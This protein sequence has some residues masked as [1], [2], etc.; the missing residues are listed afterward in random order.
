MILRPITMTGV[1]RTTS[2]VE[3]ADETGNQA[4]ASQST[5]LSLEERFHEAERDLSNTVTLLILFDSI[6][7][8]MLSMGSLGFQERTASCGRS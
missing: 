3:D 1:I 5:R 2:A 7:S 8:K 4:A 6:C